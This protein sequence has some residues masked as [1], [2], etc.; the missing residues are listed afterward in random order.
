MFKN[1]FEFIRT[2][3]FTQIYSSGTINSNTFSVAPSIVNDILKK[4]A[5]PFMNNDHKPILQLVCSK[6]SNTGYTV[7]I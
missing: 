7:P 4:Y 6:D 2:N 5:V 1:T 3:F